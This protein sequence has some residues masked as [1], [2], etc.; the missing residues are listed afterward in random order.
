[1]REKGLEPERESRIDTCVECVVRERDLSQKTVYRCELCDR[2]FCEKHIEPRLA[3]IKDL[4]A[5]DNIPE[6]RV[7]YHTEIEGK[8]GQGHPD[9]EYSRRKFRQLDIEE[10]RRNELIKQALDRMNHYY[11]DVSIPEKPTD[12]EA[13]R[14]KRVEILLREERELNE[15]QK[16]DVKSS[17][18]ITTFGNFYGYRFVVPREVYSNAQYREYLNYAKTMK[19]VR[20]IVDEYYRKYPKRKKD[21]EKPNKKKH[22]WQ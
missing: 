20:V 13:D 5:I 7:L 14:K 8:E 17:Q 12:S 1:L 3:F 19:S 11:D 22:W 16:E 18:T 6:V 15:P 2:W 21:L 10:K 9:F 4:E